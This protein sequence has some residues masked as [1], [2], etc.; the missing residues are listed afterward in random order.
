MTGQQ[1][2]EKSFASALHLA[3]SALVIGAVVFAAL[4]VWYPS[5]LLSAVGGHE[6]LG[7]IALCDV[8]LG[9]LLTFVVYERNKRT[10][11]FDLA[12]I[13]LFQIAALIY[14]VHTLWAG[15]PVYLAS[16]GERFDLVQ[17]SEVSM[18]S[19]ARV[20]GTLPKFGPVWVGFRRPADVQEQ[21]K[22]IFRALEGKDYGN[23]PEHHAP[24]D[25]MNAQMLQSAQ[26]LKKLYE[27]NPRETDE[28]N[29]WLKQKDVT[30]E[31]V[32][33]LGLKARVRDMAVMLHADSG[34][35]IGIA[36]FKPWE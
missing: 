6:L 26:P 22:M 15:R 30:P 8:A 18:E 13:A 24:L 34:L 12:V 33:Y 36:P 10:L 1:L 9:P 20:N 27:L 5:P 2:R 19:L 11:R 23:F 32:R 31:R 29:R 17:A 16:I 21:Q 4:S 14:G 7:L 28:I 35:V 3:L 25:T